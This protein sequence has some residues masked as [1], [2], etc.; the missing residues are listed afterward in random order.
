MTDKTYIFE[1]LKYDTPITQDFSSGNYYEILLISKGSCHFELD[2]NAINC[3]TES[4]VFLKP[5][6]T[7]SMQ[8]SSNKYHLELLTLR[9]LPSLLVE[10]SDETCDLEKGFSILHYL[11]LFSSF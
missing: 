3:N 5:N 8:F 2:N 7:I 1:R 11:L 6:E 10:L 4:A 9:I